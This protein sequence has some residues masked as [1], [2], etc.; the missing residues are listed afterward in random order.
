MRPIIE[1]VEICMPLRRDLPWV[2]RPRCSMRVRDCGGNINCWVNTHI[3]ETPK[4]CACPR[5]F[6]GV[7]L[8]CCSG[9]IWIIRAEVHRRSWGVLVRRGISTFFEGRRRHL[10]L[11]HVQLVSRQWFVSVGEGV[12]SKGA[13]PRV[14]WN[15]CR[16]WKQF[17]P[18]SYNGR[19]L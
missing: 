5:A 14:P 7:R 12:G 17:Q 4:G 11:S 13:G 10:L 19:S 8:H 16:R 1:K 6:P 2:A 15:R 18:T 3:S 9:K